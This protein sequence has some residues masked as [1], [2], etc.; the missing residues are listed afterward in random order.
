MKKGSLIIILVL[1]GLFGC[2]DKTPHQATEPVNPKA[3]TLTYYL[4]DSFPHDTSLFTEGFLVH[5][6]MIFESTG[7]PEEFSATR[8]V[9]GLQDLKT[10]NLAIKIE[11]DKN[12][13]FGEG[14]AILKNKLYQLTYKNQQGFIYD[15]NTFKKLR[16]FHY[17]NLE[18]W[19]LTTDGK[20]LIMSDG[21]DLLTFL[22]PETLRPVKILKVTENGAPVINLNEMEF[23]K[24]YIYANIWTTNFIMKIDPSNGIVV[25]KLDFN[26][27][28]AQ[29]KSENINAQEMN[30][31]AYDSAANKVYVTGK[32]WSKI[33]QVQINQ[34]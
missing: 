31:I 13:Y 7:S 27:L 11:L 15:A 10:G 21:T 18:G 8:S 19:G 29:Q 25:G 6:G 3:P 17:S 34:P 4:K 1:I 28:A 20:E 33:Y 26:R 24:G 5:N 32:L 23:I 2:H 30:G 22:N 14:I 12:K 16:D 9:I